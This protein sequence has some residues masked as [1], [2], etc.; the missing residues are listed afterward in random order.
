MPNRLQDSPPNVGEF[1][2]KLRRS[3]GLTLEDL[4][5]GSG[6]SKS[7]LSQIERNKTNPTLATVWRLCECL[8]VSVDA[9]FGREDKP[10]VLD[11]L[12]AH[13]TPSIRSADGKIE[14]RILGPLD[15]GGLV[16]WY[17]VRAEPG[18]VLASQAHDPGTTEHLTVLEG[19]LAIEVGGEIRKVAIDE[20]VR[21][22]ADQP[23]AIRNDTSKPA[24]ALLVV[25]L[26]RP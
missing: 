14:A 4:S 22:R 17:E 23:H 25:M 20:T 2:R 1:V 8:G 24:R 16:E 12:Q 21:Y 11:V 15:L 18:A 5:E 7:M 26:H 6:V 3:R 13:A 19:V 10:P 9:M